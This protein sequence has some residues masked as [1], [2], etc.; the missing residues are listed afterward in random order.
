M[1][2][3]RA[4]A[5]FGMVL[6]REDRLVPELQPF[7]AAVEQRDMRDLGGWRQRLRQHAEAVVLAGD[8]DLAGDQVLHRM[9]GA[10]VADRH[11]ARLAAERQ[12]QELV[13]EAYAEEPPAPR[14]QGAGHPNR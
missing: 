4:G 2:V 12:R 14:Q 3:L 9:I 7:V 10:A 11:L 13:A 1:A 5:G 8:L 6:P